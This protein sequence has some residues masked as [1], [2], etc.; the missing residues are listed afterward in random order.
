MTRF[1]PAYDVEHAEL[2]LPGV[3]RLAALHRRFE[4]PATF[5]IVGKLLE[6]DGPAFRKLLDDPL[7]DVQTHTYSHQALKDSRAWGAGAGLE[8]MEVEVREGKRLVEEVFERECIGLRPGGGFENGWQ[9]CPDRLEILHRHGLKFV[10][11]D[12]RGPMDS[13]PA[14][15]KQAYTYEADGFG[16]LWEIPG[17]GWHD[18]ALK[19]HTPHTTFFP[20]IYDFALPPRS[21]QTVVEVFA[22]EG[23]WLEHGVALELEYVSLVQHPWSIYSFDETMAPMELLLTRARQLGMKLMTYLDYYRELAGVE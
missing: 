14:P 12:L 20:P 9:G 15:L 11:A 18:N 2:C 16:D 8:V 5:F 13:I 1:L 7:F 4:A 22:Q 23:R 10:S 21:P 19:R 3:E 6:K 17:H